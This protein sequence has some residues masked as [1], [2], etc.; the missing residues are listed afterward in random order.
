M[1]IQIVPFRK[2]MVSRY[3]YVHTEICGHTVHGD[4]VGRLKKKLENWGKK[5]SKRKT[6][7]LKW[8]WI[9]FKTTRAVF[10]AVTLQ[11]ATCV[12]ILAGLFELFVLFLILLIICFVFT[13]PPPFPLSLKQSYILSD[14]CSKLELFLHLFCWANAQ[15]FRTGMSVLK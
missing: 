6:K 12:C 1:V 7:V 10:Q 14:H 8:S 13:N 11:V 15:S 2:K 9:C 5:D 4:I 3:E